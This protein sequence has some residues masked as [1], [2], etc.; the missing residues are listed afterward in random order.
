MKIFI[1]IMLLLMI[2]CNK[3][4][5]KNDPVL[6]N[7]NDKFMLETID[8]KISG[9]GNKQTLVIDSIYESNIF[10][11]DL[12]IGIS[13]DPDFYKND[14]SFTFNEVLPDFLHK[15]TPQKYVEVENDEI[16]IVYYPHDFSIHGNYIIQFITIKTFTKKYFL[17]DLIGKTSEYIM[18]LF[19]ESL[20]YLFINE[21]GKGHIGFSSKG[22]IYF[23]TFMFR[24]NYLYSISYGRNI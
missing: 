15:G 3:E 22:S 14:I 19:S 12:F 21:G 8:S 13:E 9:N 2:S 23:V 16:K 10:N 1:V 20:E 5:E 24:D 6:H 18:A 4:W 17:G 7:T 11:N